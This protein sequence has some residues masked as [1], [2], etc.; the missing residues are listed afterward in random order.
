MIFGDFFMF[1]TG[2]SMQLHMS[3]GGNRKNSLTRAE[4]RIK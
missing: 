2:M 4:L 3:P 1:N